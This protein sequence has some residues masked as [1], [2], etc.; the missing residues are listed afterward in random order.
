[1]V[2][3]EESYLEVVIT[4]SFNIAVQVGFQ[5]PTYVGMESVGEVRVCAVLSANIAR[6]IALELTAT[7][8]S[9]N[10]ICP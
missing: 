7:A 9:A 8:G 2:G 4:I 5:S 3:L 10:G 6:S 1:M